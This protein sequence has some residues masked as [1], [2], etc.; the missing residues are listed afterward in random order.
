MTL[1]PS[2][3]NAARLVAKGLQRTVPANDKEYRELLSLYE[4][5]PSFRSVVA[6]VAVG[7]TLAV[8]SGSSR[9]I[10]LMPADQDSRF[11]YRLGD[12]RSG[13]APDEKAL[14]VLIHTTIAAQFYPTGDSLDDEMYQAPPVTERQVLTALKQVCQHLAGLE[15]DSAQHLPP[16]LEPGWKSVLLKP[17]ARPD[18]QRRTPSTIEGLVALV[19]KQLE[20]AGLV[21]CQL[22]DGSK[23]SYTANWRL[24][25]QL[26]ESTSRIFS[27]TREALA[28]HDKIEATRQGA[29]R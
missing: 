22:S 25:V 20:D 24:T 21:S 12:I 19:F 1:E 6:D 18:Q 4:E 9:G 7:M 27:A 13:L 28:R 15:S 10:V 16:E 26:R 14:V 3:R 8:L 2:A 29:T 23:S 5:D 17:E 11:A